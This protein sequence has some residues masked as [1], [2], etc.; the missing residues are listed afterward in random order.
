MAYL[1]VPHG[2]TDRTATIWVGAI[3]QSLNQAQL[4][5]NGN[6][7]HIQWAEKTWTSRNHMYTL[8]Y[9]RVTLTGL[10]PRKNYA[11]E[12]RV[13]GTVEA[14]GQVRTLPTML[15]SPPDD[16]F[17][18]LLGS[19]FCAPRDE[20]GAVGN[21]YFHLPPR[22][23]PDVK[24]LCGDQVYLDHPAGHFLRYTHT[25][26]EMEMKF[27]ENYVRVWTQ[28]G[29][30]AG[31]RELLR[32]GANYFSSD[33]HELWNNAPSWATVVR[34]SWTPTGREQWLRIGREL[35]HAF[36]AESAVEQFSVRPL[37][38][39]IADT[40]IDRDGNLQKFMLDADF[41]KMGAWIHGLQGPGVLVL[42]QPILT[43]K[44]GFWGRFSDW[45][46]PNYA[47]YRDLVQVIRSSNHSIVILTGDVHYGRVASCSLT[48]G[49]ELIEIISSPTALVNDLVG[50][51]WNPAPDVFPASDMP[52]VAK[53]PV[54]TE[55]AFTLTDNHFLTLQFS[56]SGAQVQMTVKAWPTS[57]P[58][59]KPTS[60]VVYERPLS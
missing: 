16:P 4:L 49:V 36:Q 47:Q 55:S 3:N 41:Q 8:R 23:R 34:D 21:T 5:L 26:D 33:D 2:V 6:D 1:L 50:K 35:Y 43:E 12:L 31:F 42:G 40:R 60:R 9:Q 24:I 57:N 20:E 22:E 7:Q 51:K 56:R 29:I 13:G 52:G 54:R 44:K 46:L 58:G 45:N 14:A 30:A 32:N 37:S 11:V 27:F 17:T 10:E 15:P 53:A 28:S 19:C 18:V 38:F 59:S 25:A 39:C 48:P